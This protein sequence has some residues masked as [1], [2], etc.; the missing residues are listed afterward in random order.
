LI[1]GH[2]VALGNLPDKFSIERTGM[3]IGRQIDREGGLPL[4]EP[5]LDSAAYGLLRGGMVE[6]TQRIRVHSGNE[7]WI[8]GS[9][10]PAHE[11][12]IPYHAP[13]RNID[14]RLIG[15]NKVR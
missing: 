4:T 8:A 13:G 11:S 15:N 10:F 2:S 6:S 3:K 14:N 9:S 7:F 5:K 12:F 1:D